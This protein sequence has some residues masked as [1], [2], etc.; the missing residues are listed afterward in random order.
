MRAASWASARTRFGFYI[1]SPNSGKYRF[2]HP[3]KVA[4]LLGVPS[5]ITYSD[6]LKSDLC[7]LGLIASP[8]WIYAQLWCNFAKATARDTVLTPAIIL[9]NYQRELL[10]QFAAARPNSRTINEVMTDEGLS[11]QLPSQCAIPAH[12]VLLAERI[13]NG[14]GFNRCF[15]NE[16]GQPDP[17]PQLR[18]MSS[19]QS[20]KECVLLHPRTTSASLSTTARTPYAPGS[21]LAPSHFSHSAS[22][23]ANTTSSMMS[24]TTSLELTMEL[25][26]LSQS[27]QLRLHPLVPF[28]TPLELGPG[29]NHLAILQHPRFSSQ[30]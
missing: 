19:T 15:I 16:L 8:I 13:N 25:G 1:H 22:R 30:P 23:V 26:A 17:Q 12:A 27:Q 20:P 18:R 9:R 29:L 5:S 6:D 3:R 21:S 4:L 11:L 28:S 7:L 14:W 2:L 24:S 10:S